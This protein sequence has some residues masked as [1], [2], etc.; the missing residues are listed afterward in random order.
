VPTS[1]LAAIIL[2]LVGVITYGVRALIRGDIVPR[3]LVEDRKID[4]N[5]R[6]AREKEISDLRE[7]ANKNLIEAINRQAVQTERLVAEQ[8][9][10]ADVMRGLE[11]ASRA[12]SER[13]N[14]KLAGESI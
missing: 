10:T 9:T 11:A 1:L 12:N 3:K 8:K 5:E 4:S 13:D 7:E 14:S 6:L 2:S